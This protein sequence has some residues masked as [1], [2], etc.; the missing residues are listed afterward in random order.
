M[1]ILGRL[2]ALQQREDHIRQ[3]IVHIEHK[4]AAASTLS[5]QARGQVSARMD[6]ENSQKEAVAAQRDAVRASLRDE[7]EGGEE[8]G[9][10]TGQGFKGG[11]NQPEEI[12]EEFR[13]RRE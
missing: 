1:W 13:K 7:L 8:R 9:R 5:Q 10:V 4:M 11:L 6:H 3:R 2:K 12:L